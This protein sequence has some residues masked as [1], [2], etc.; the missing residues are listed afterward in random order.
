MNM[1]I[2]INNKPCACEPGEYLLDIASRNGIA[3][4][5]LC[6]HDGLRGQA[7]CRVCIVEVETDGRRSIVTACVYPIERECAVFT[8]NENV[9][10]QRRM[11]LRL[12]R[13][14]A[15]QSGEVARLCEEYGAAEVGDRF[16]KNADGKCI[17]CALCVEACRS[18]GT[19]AIGTAGRGVGKDVT[20]PY[21]EPSLACV[22]CASCAS[23]CPTGCIEVGE[24]GNQ[25][26]I[27]NKTFPLVA[28]KNCGAVMGTMMELWRA[29]Q[30][31]GA[32]D[33][34]V[35]CEMCRKKAITDVMAATYGK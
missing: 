35:L 24:A 12:L 30:K 5:S 23:V 1:T 9:K 25:R 11:V 34:P 32:E 29:A 22:G 28:C 21:D 3:I 17:L 13:A 2:N 15:P 18:L 19:G 20:T 16:E 10:R 14:R 4:P 27:W 31:T 8:E 26:T 6:H 7:C 33:A